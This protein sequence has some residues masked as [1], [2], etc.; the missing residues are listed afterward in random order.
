MSKTRINSRFGVQPTD[1]PT[2]KRI[3]NLVGLLLAREFSAAYGSGLAFSA[4][5]GS[6]ALAASVGALVGY[7]LSFSGTAGIRYMACV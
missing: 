5:A 2:K 6:Y 1:K 7:L 3:I 4:A